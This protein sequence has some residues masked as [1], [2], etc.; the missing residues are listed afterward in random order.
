MGDDLIQRTLGDEDAAVPAGAGP[1][2]DDVIGSANHPLIVFNDE[3]RVPN[4]SE[5]SQRR[6]QASIVALM[7]TDRRLI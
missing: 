3:H 5:V 2:V 1:D 6:D 7:Q 4:V